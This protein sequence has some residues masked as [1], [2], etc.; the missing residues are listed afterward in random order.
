[1]PLGAGLDGANNGGHANFTTTFT[2]HYQG[3]HTPAL[4][5]P[6]FARGPDSNTPIEVPNNGAAG[7][8]ITLYNAANVTDVTFSLTYN[9]SLLNI[10]GT[11]SGT[12]Q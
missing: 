5:L 3:Q 11:V 6:D 7:I 10:L 2:T 4:G 9:A 1:M 12:K 8:P